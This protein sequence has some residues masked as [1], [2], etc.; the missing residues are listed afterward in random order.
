[1][2]LPR[3]KDKVP[4]MRRGEAMW[5]M[6]GAFALL[7]LGVVMVRAD[8]PEDMAAIRETAMNYM[9][10]WYRGDAATMK[11]SLHRKLAK[12][13][14]RGIFGEKGFRHTSA[15]EM[16]RYTINGGGKNLWRQGSRI[17][18]RVLDHYRDIATVKV[19]SPDYY[20]YLH[21]ARIAGRWVIVNA[22]YE[23]NTAAGEKDPEVREG[24]RSK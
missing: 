15:S 7:L 6:L 14:L 13:S 3:K 19:V 4:F 1:M 21:L 5:K 17:E 23:P 8:G 22:L 18:V 10:S 12:R 2:P 11:A 24:H 20:E 16:V 9:V